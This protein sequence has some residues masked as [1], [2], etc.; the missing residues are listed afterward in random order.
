MRL[1]VLMAS[2]RLGSPWLM[3][4]QPH[5]SGAAVAARRLGGRWLQACASSSAA[6]E[7]PKQKQ[8]NKGGKG[9]GGGSQKGLTS[10]DTDFSA[11]YNEVRIA[12][13]PTPSC[14]PS[15]TEQCCISENDVL[16]AQVI[17]AADLVDQS[18][19]KGCMV[20]KPNGMGL[21]EAVRDDLDRRIKATGA[22]SA[23]FPLFIP[24]CLMF[25]C[26]VAALPLCEP[27]F[28]SIQSSRE[29]RSL[30]LAKRQSTLR[31]LRR[32]VRSS[33]ITA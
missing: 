5:A 6:V 1:M 25:R 10:R 22:Q 7:K 26:T 33:H 19:V 28:D 23:Y 16:P 14:C 20:I 21:W 30:S 4:T 24:V 29:C 11:W 8:R 18:P 17:T 32:S 13:C 3:G 9:G 15:S 12:A 27:L 2:L 31:G